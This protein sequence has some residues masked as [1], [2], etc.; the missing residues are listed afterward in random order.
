MSERSEVATIVLR[1]SGGLSTDARRRLPRGAGA[2]RSATT[3]DP[4]RGMRGGIAELH[5][6]R[7][8]ANSAVK[9]GVRDSP[10]VLSRMAARRFG[11]RC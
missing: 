7:H 1:V 8:L 3:T 9:F 5:P 6:N 2:A 4:R 10:L 11:F